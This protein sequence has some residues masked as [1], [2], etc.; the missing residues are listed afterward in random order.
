M[1]ALLENFYAKVKAQVKDKISGLKA[2]DLKFSATLDEWTSMKNIRFINVNLHFPVE[3]NKAKYLN[4]GMIKID[5]HC[6]AEDMVNLV[7]F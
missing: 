6:T 4:L 7:R 5:I 3:Y 2:K 1:V